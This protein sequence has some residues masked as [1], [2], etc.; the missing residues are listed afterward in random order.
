MSIMSRF[1]SNDRLS[2]YNK[3]VHV[4]NGRKSHSGN[5]PSNTGTVGKL[6]RNGRS[7]IKTD[8][9]ETP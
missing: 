6:E 9:V 8:F 7:E 2:K 4:N 3:Q 5:G 1:P